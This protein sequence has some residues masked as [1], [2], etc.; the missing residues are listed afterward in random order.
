MWFVSFAQIYVDLPFPC[1]NVSIG[2][3]G[4]MST[5]YGNA[6]NLLVYSSAGDSTLTAAEYSHVVAFYAGLVCVLHWGF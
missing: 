1:R 4:I 2:P 3:E 5:V 6:I